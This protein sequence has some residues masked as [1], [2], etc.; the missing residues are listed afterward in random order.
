MPDVRLT[1]DGL[2][3][4]THAG[5]TILQV[6]QENRIHVPTLC[7]FDGLPDVGACRLCIVEIERQRRPMPACTTPAENGMVIKTNTPIL[8]SL[9]R[10]TIELLLGERNHICPFCPL[11]GN[12]RL[13]QAAYDLGVDHVRYDYL[14]PQL[15][16]DNTHRY[17]ALDHNRCIL[18]TRCIR[19]CDEWVGAHVLDLDHR[20]PSTVL[21]ADDGVPCGQSSCVSCG[22][23]I[24]VCPTGAMFEKRCAH[25]QGRVPFELTETICPGCSVGCRIHASVLY[26]QIGELSSAGGPSG[27]RLLCER[28]RFGLGNPTAAR[29]ETVRIKRARDWAG[30]TLDQAVER[31]VQRLN[32]APIQADPSRVIA[33]ISSRVPLEVQATCQGFMT[34]VVG[35][36]RWGVFDRTN[37][38]SIRQAFKMNGRLP[39]LAGL[40]DLE[41]AD[42]FLLLG[43]NLERSTGVIASYVR[44]A[45]LHRRAKLVKINPRH[46]WLTDWTDLHIRVERGRDPLLLAAILKYLLDDG[47]AKVDLPADLASRLSRIDDVDVHSLTG[48]EGE[49]LRRVA[50]MYAQAERPMIL[51]GRGLTRGGPE[52]LVGALNLVRAMNRKTPDGRWRLMELAIGSN[53][54][55][56]RLLGPSGLHI[57][58]FDPHTAE[59]AFVILGGVD[60]TWPRERLERLRAVS[61]VVALSPREHEVTELAHVVIPTASWAERSGTFIN[62]EGRVQKGRRLMEPMAGCVEDGAFFQQLAKVWK[63]PDC[64]WSPPDLPAVIADLNDGDMTPVDPCDDQVDTSG[65]EALARE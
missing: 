5:Q 61:F 32:G 53:S 59:M 46:T 54:I 56:A 7:H 55:G 3:I 44:R 17:I 12:C 33:L 49:Q 20:G 30:A 14:F 51:C 4:T 25:W 27:N 16:V 24:S 39:P 35:S 29:T 47:H 50:E 60:P 26:R 63:G 38:A 15:P 31:C 34:R 19:A 57:S 36:D 18:C 62:L 13:Q 9:R 11:S 2:E 6:C 64:D 45:V 22:A 52:G 58:S 48:V 8:Q 28:G 40:R 21:I 41:D 10:Q 65:L 37:P 1:I 42:M 43:C 23:C